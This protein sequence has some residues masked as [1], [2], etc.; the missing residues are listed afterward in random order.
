MYFGYKPHIHQEA[1]IKMSINLNLPVCIPFCIEEMLL[2]PRNKI[3][4]TGDKLAPQQRMDGVLIL[5]LNPKS[6]KQWLK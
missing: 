1:R 4:Q 3:E 5:T 2:L 6:K